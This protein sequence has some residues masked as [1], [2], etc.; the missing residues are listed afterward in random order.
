MPAETVTTG[1]PAKLT[2]YS[3]LRT[4]LTSGVTIGAVAGVIWGYGALCTRV[5]GAC[6]RLD[7]HDAQIVRMEQDRERD[8]REQTA[9]FME[10]NTSVQETRTDVKWIKNQLKAAQ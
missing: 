3:V 7:K 5:E 1:A 4:I 6:D 2:V 10:L 8:T 9:L